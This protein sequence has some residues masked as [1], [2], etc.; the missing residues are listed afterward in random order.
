MIGGPIEQQLECDILGRRTDR[1]DTVAR[2]SVIAVTLSYGRGSETMAV[3]RHVVGNDG[4]TCRVL[5]QPL[6]LLGC[7]L[8]GLLRPR[9]SW[10]VVR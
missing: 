7:S 8:P 3:N 9:R 6:S 4:V 2:W 5:M 1:G 10:R